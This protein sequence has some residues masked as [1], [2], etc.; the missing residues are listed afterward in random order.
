M[1]LG[2][3]TC[4]EKRIS[5]LSKRGSWPFRAGLGQFLTRTIKVPEVNQKQPEMDTDCLGV[6]K[7]PGQRAEVGERQHRPVLVVEPDRRRREG[8]RVVRG[9]PRSRAELP[10]GRNRPQSLMVS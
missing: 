9:Q 8:F 4:L 1:V 7:A 5:P 6:R 2:L 10:F 3:S